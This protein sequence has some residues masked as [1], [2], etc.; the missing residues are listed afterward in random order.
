MLEH[1]LQTYQAYVLRMEHSHG[2]L[3]QYLDS[4]W[5]HLAFNTAF[6]LAILPVAAQRG[7]PRDLR[8]QLF[9]GGLAVAGYHVVEHAAKTWQSVMMGHDPALGIAGH[10]GPLIPIHLW[11][12]LV[13]FLLV[14]PHLLR[15]A[16]A[17]RRPATLATGSAP[18]R[19]P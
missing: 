13:V 11:L 5:I 6:L 1:V 16:F 18:S 15:W 12:N 3:G 9:L 8:F 19:A 10:Y 14:V 17:L 7:D 4:D 2:L